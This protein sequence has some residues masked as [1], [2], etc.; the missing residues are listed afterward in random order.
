M[1]RTDPT[2]VLTEELAAFLS[3]G[4]AISIATRDGD[5]NPNGTRVWA[6]VADEDRRLVTAYL[7]AKTSDTILR[8]L[9]AHPLVALGFDRPSDSRACQL[10][11]K[12]LGSARC[13]AADRAEIDRQFAGFLADLEKIGFP[14]PAFAGWKTWP[15]VAVRF[16]VTDVFV[17]TPGPGA[18][19]RL[20]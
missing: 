19:E 6:A 7:Y 18:G 3:S 16:A 14:R 15:A 9:E 2:V 11:G 17:Q 5:L 13:R 8:D 1:A 4:V 10:K 20:R 12:F